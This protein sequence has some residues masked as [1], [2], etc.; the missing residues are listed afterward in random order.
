[1]K[2]LILSFKAGEGHNS[3]AKAI[4]ER[5][6]HEGHQGEVVDFL[7]LFSDKISNAV[8]LA[9]VGMVKHM[10]SLFGVC[11]KFSYGVSNVF[12]KVH[13]PLYLDS[14]IVAR[15]LYDYLEKNGPY[16]GIVATHL[17]PAQALSH[18]KKHNCEYVSDMFFCLRDGG[19]SK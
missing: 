17:M 19:A 3:A 9:Y 8:N 12:K 10:P 15:R 14:A 6:E 7:G 18:L 4:L 13:S 1:M 16:D 2:I 11:Y 5:I